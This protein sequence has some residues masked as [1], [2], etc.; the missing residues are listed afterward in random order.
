MLTAKADD[1]RQRRTVTV[2]ELNHAL[3]RAQ[4]SVLKPN[5]FCSV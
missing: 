2:V 5:L 1:R 4:P 3:V